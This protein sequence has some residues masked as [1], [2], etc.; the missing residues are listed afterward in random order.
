[1]P[2]NSAGR[3]CTGTVGGIRCKK[4][5]RYSSSPHPLWACL[6]LW[7]FNCFWGRVVRYM[8]GCCSR[9]VRELPKLYRSSPEQ[10][11]KKVHQR[12]LHPAGFA[13][14]DC[15]GCTLNFLAK[16]PLQLTLLCRLFLATSTISRHYAAINNNT[17]Q[18]ITIGH[19]RARAA[20]F[21]GQNHRYHFSCCGS[22]ITTAAIIY[23]KSNFYGFISKRNPWRILRKGWHRNRW[24]LER[25]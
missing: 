25:H 13:A 14:P 5:C 6:L 9:H 23:P 15:G 3:Y 22:A 21:T 11:P 12:S 10:A 4:K 16:G 1:M 24:Q 8:F 2:Q 7:R 18:Y 17:P 19:N 20:K